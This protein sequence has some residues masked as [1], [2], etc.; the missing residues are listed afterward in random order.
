MSH[1]QV[2]AWTEDSYIVPHNQRAG[3]RFGSSVALNSKYAFFGAVEVDQEPFSNVGAVYVYRLSGSSWIYD[4]ML[5]ASNKNANNYFGASVAATDSLAVIG[6]YGVSVN[7]QSFVGSAYIFALEGGKWVEKQI[8]TSGRQVRYDQFGYSV[9]LNDQY[10]IIGR[11]TGINAGYAS[12]AGAVYFYSRTQSEWRLEVIAEAYD[13]SNVDLFG[14]SLSTSGKYVAI[15]AYG[16]DSGSIMD[17]GAAYIFR[18]DGVSWTFDTKLTSSTQTY[19]EYFGISISMSG[20]H[21]LVGTLTNTQLFTNT[22]SGWNSQQ[23]LAVAGGRNGIF[24]SESYGIIYNSIYS[25]S[26]DGLKLKTPLSRTPGFWGAVTLTD[27]HAVISNGDASPNGNSRG[28]E[29]YIFKN[30]SKPACYL[31]LVFQCHNH[32]SE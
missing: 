25:L 6:A 22:G 2:E 26:D 15:G 31:F 24:L 10:V 8:L 23:T 20:N 14:C 27:K 5:T 29:A 32:S 17:A 7:G 4:D 16:A 28:G 21:T 12:H 19:G 9:H 1:M 13:K 30:N 18:Y 11:P 3:D